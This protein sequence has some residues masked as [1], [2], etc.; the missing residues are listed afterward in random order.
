M[1]GLKAHRPAGKDRQRHKIPRCLR[2]IFRH[3]PFPAQS[4]LIFI[5]L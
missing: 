1:P 4:K 2:S 3:Y 5:D